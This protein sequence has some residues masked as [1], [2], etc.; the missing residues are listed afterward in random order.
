LHVFGRDAG[1]LFLGGEEVAA[2]VGSPL[3]VE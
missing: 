2:G 1:G 3:K